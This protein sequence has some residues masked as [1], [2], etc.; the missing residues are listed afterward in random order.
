M[1]GALIPTLAAAVVVALTASLGAWQLRRGAEKDE[2]A[3]LHRRAASSAPTIV[4]GT[5]VEA[6]VVDGRRVVVSGTFVPAGTVFLDNRT[7]RGVAGFHVM[8]PLRIGAGADAMHVLVLRG[9]VARDLADR[10]RLPQVTTPG[11]VVR[12]EGAA[13]AT[14]AQPITLGAD[15]DPEPRERLW[16][17][18][19][20]D[21]YARWSG[22]VLQPFLLRQ[23]SEL[24]DGLERDWT[25]PGSGADK[26]RAYAAQ[27]FAM[28]IVTAGLW[29]WFVPLRRARSARGS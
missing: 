10:S 8:T 22:L 6:S 9:W 15:P 2:L 25:L 12:I 5:P 4:D 17:H 3:D 1:R 21:R 13:Q 19:T 28:A 14:L 7:R 18:W 24:D 16:Q 23:T 20:R 26:H 11:G 27:W 29:V